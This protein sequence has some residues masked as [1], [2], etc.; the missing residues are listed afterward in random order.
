MSWFS[1]GHIRLYELKDSF[2]VILLH[3]LFEKS[4]LSMNIVS[5]FFGNVSTHQDNVLYHTFPNDQ[6]ISVNLY[7]ISVP[8]MSLQGWNREVTS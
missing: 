1:M 7:E 6:I 3:V 5:Q 4:H 2:T 8:Q